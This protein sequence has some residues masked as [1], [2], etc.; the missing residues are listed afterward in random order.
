[1]IH[2]HNMQP[3]GCLSRPEITGSTNVRFRP[4]ADICPL[5]K[6][7]PSTVANVAP[8]SDL[9]NNRF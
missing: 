7:V 5:R 2:V 1:L 9:E 3:F 6:F 4:K 8:N